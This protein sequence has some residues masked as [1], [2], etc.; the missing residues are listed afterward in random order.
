MRRILLVALLASLCQGCFVLEEID[1]GHQLMDQHSPRAREK[2]AQEKEAR[3]APRSA[4][5]GAK[6]EEGTLEGLKEWWK[7][8]REPAPPQ[9]EP[10]DVVTRCRIGG[11]VHFVRKSDCMLRG[12]Q[13]I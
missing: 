2:A 1:K 9:R 4:R 12:G 3:E 5:A 11:T 8:K 13:V 10:D 6:Q 7:K